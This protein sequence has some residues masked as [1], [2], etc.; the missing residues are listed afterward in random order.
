[1][2]CY[3][4]LLANRTFLNEKGDFIQGKRII[5]PNM[6]GITEFVQ[7]KGLFRENMNKNRSFVQGAAGQ[8]MSQREKGRREMSQEGRA[9]Q[10]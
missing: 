7:I 8:P 1:M 4:F 2:F 6:N 5:L 3:V 9:Q 10:R